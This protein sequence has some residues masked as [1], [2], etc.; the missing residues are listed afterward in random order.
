MTAKTRNRN[1]NVMEWFGGIAMYM[2]SLEYCQKHFFENMEPERAEKAVAICFGRNA[3]APVYRVRR[4][5]GGANAG[6]LEVRR[7]IA[8]GRV[9]TGEKRRA[10]YRINLSCPNDAGAHQHHYTHRNHV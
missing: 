10:L 6:R 2:K 5:A 9:R 8:T 7:K 1:L 4:D 3:C